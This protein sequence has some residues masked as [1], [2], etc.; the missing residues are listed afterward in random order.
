MKDGD[1]IAES[2]YNELMS[3]STEPFPI[4]RVSY[5]T[6]F[7]DENGIRNTIS[8]QRAALAP[9]Q[10]IAS[11]KSSKSP[12]FRPCRAQE[13]DGDPGKVCHELLCRISRQENPLQ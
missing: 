4:I 2:T 13:L 10:D 7:I 12:F 11:V 3:K 1:K 8:I 9:E 6:L 5:H